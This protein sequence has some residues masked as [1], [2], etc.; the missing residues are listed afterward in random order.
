MDEKA[1]KIILILSSA[2]VLAIALTSL[3]IAY[4]GGMRGIELATVCFFLT[5]GI[6]VVLAQVMPAGILLGSLAG[7]AISLVRSIEVSI[8]AT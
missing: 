8:R 1:G 3:G 7:A 5:S 4:V 2:L 6:V